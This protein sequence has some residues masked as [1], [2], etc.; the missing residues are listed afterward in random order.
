MRGYSTKL[1]GTA[2]PTTAGRRAAQGW[3]AR[4]L[5]EPRRVEVTRRDTAEPLRFQFRRRWAKVGRQFLSAR[6]QELLRA[7]LPIFMGRW[8]SSCESKIRADRIGPAAARLPTPV[9]LLSGI[10]PDR[11]AVR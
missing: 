4:C 1:G 8:V 5:Y 6:P 2:D 3:R 10:V 9:I 11:G 7:A